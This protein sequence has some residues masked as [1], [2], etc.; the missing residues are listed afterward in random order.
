[1]T[2]FDIFIH[3]VDFQYIS[4]RPDLFDAYLKPTSSGFQNHSFALAD[5][6][7]LAESLDRACSRFGCE[8]L[9]VVLP[10]KYRDKE[11]LTEEVAAE[12]ARRF[13]EVQEPWRIRRTEIPAEFSGYSY[14]F[15]YVAQTDAGKVGG[16][17][18]IE[19]DALDGHIIGAREKIQIRLTL[20]SRLEIR[21]ID[22][23][24]ARGSKAEKLSALTRL[25]KLS[26]PEK[27]SMLAI[28][29]KLEED[30][31]VLGEIRKQIG[32]PD[33]HD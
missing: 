15:A 8:R 17:G 24:L 21:L 31:E 1:M 12:K 13:V 11:R 16:L 5:I 14:A 30:D 6:T 25:G 2:K 28:Y 27:H 23:D 26:G 20:S 9:G 3:P 19:V 18:T 7:T 10:T 4:E 22:H 33:L 32:Q 29:E